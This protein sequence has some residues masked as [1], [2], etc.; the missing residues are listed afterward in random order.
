MDEHLPKNIVWRT[1]KVGFEP[2]Q[3]QWMQQPVLQEMMMESRRLLAGEGILK[4][5]IMNEPVIAMDA[6]GA[7]NYDWRYLNAATIIGNGS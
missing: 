7:G 4:T 5:A 6:H 2:P 1:D 3:K